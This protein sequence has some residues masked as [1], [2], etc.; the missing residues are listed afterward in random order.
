MLNIITNSYCYRWWNSKYRK[1][2]SF[3][4]RSIISPPE[5]T[6]NNFCSQLFS[7]ILEGCSCVDTKLHHL[8][9][10]HNHILYAECRKGV[11]HG[12]LNILKAWD[13]KKKTEIELFHTNIIHYTSP[14]TTFVV[15]AQSLYL[16]QEGD[17]SGTF[18]IY[19]T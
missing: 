14:Y 2:Y 7:T 1:T 9:I 4:Q 19:S 5:S 16:H 8:S 12:M 15:L 11:R 6:E 13:K 17:T 10:W 3:W 18:F